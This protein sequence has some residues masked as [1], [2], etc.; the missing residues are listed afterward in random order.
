MLKAM[1][2]ET[3]AQH[4]IDLLARIRVEIPD[5]A[6]RTTFIVGFPG[7]MDEH[8][9]RLLEFLEEVRFE[10]MGVFPYSEEEGSRATKMEGQVPMRFNR[11]VGARQ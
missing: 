1:R 4:I 11:P 9:N 5:I 10:R 7:E 8:L 3:S 2:R 6:I